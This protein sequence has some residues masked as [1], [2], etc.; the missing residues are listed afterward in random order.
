MECGG[1]KKG[2]DGRGEKVGGVELE[3][4]VEGLLRWNDLFNIIKAT[5][6]VNFTD[7]SLS[8]R[9]IISYMDHDPLWQFHNSE[10]KHYEKNI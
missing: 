10:Q 8:S 1:I 2:G 6:Q 3:G 5:K 9:L 7:I 4:N